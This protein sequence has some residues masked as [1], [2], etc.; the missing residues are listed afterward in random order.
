MRFSIKS[1]IHALQSEILEAIALG[2][3]FEAVADLLCRRVEALAPAATCSILRIKDGRVKPVAGPSL[4][5]HY[6]QALDGLEVGPCVG[7]CGTAAYRGEPVMVTD[8]ATD[9][10]WAPFKALVLPLGLKACWS[11]P[12][13]AGDGRVIATFA[14]YYRKRRGPTALERRVV[15]ACVHLCTV[16]I[17]H[18]E[19]QQ[20]NF[21][22]ARYDQLTNLPNRRCFDDLIKGR[23]RAKAPRFGLLLIDIDSLKVVNDTMGHV[24]G[25]GL[26]IEVAKRFAAID[27]PLLACRLGGDEFAAFADGCNDPAALR[28]LAENL[29]AIMK[30]PFECN[31]NTVAPRVTIGG[32]LY[33]SDGTTA[34]ALRQNADFALY[35]AKETNR[36]GYVPFEPG[37]RTSIGRRAAAITELDLAL[38]DDRIIPYYQPVVHLDGSRIVGLEALARMRTVDGNIVTAGEFL[39]AFSDSNIARRTTDRMIAKV[40]SDLRRWLD[41]GISMARVGVNLS[42]ADFLRDDLE[43]RLSIQFDKQGVPLSLLLLEVTET[44]LMNG[45]NNAAVRAIERLRKR[46]MMVALDDFGTGYASLTHL[47]TFP[48]D[49]IKIDKSFIDRLMTD[50]DSQFIVEALINLSHK[51]GLRIVAE[52]IETEAQATRLGELGCVVGQGYL[53]SHPLDF[54][55]VTSLLRERGE[56]FAKLAKIAPLRRSA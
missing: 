48:V 16:A 44:V 38:D 14:F 28:A 21:Q 3:P 39:A 1:K 18:D 42:T 55:G 6:S 51:L 15:E 13:K 40:A 7:S 41:M 33:G 5:P 37:L 45:P 56:M 26:I 50:R 4:P 9:P 47:L 35:H 53:F 23:V 25:D 17:E 19:A 46:G 52:G 30:T 20:R 10:L 2:Q 22:L 31:G 27:P 34:C 49:I 11:S 54:A 36:G 12:I 43:Q 32:V 29:G 8:I 24:V